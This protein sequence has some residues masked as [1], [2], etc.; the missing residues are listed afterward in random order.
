MAALLETTPEGAAEFLPR[1]P[2]LGELGAPSSGDRPG[3]GRPLAARPGALPDRGARMIDVIV[4]GFGS[5]RP[6]MSPPRW[7]RAAVAC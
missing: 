3:G 4:V 5:G 7:S 2:R 1:E 6:P